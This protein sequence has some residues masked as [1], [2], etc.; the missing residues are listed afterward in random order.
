[1][2]SPGYMYIAEIGSKIKIGW[3]RDPV[4]RMR[5]F[6]REFK[7]GVAFSTPVRL[8]VEKRFHLKMGNKSEWYETKFD[9]AVKQVAMWF[10]SKGIDETVRDVA[11]IQPTGGQGLRPPVSIAI[12]PEQ[13]HWITSKTPLG[14]TRS[15]TVRRVIDEA[16]KR[17]KAS[18]DL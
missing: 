14:S 5:S 16:M 13:R 17:E 6:G 2:D 7:K 9:L 1:M 15:E 11:E 18:T 3:S 10:R 12:T 4:R 8:S